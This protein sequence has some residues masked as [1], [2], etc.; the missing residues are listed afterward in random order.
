[1]FC[2]ATFHFKKKTQ[3]F[4]SG[5]FLTFFK[6]C[7]VIIRKNKLQQLFQAMCHFKFKDKDTFLLWNKTHVLGERCCLSFSFA[8]P[9]HKP[10]TL[11]YYS[12]SQQ[13][14]E[15][16]LGTSWV[17]TTPIICRQPVD[18]QGGKHEM[19]APYRY[20]CEE[21]HCGHIV[22]ESWKDGG[23]EAEDDDHRPHSSSG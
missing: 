20:G 2:P 16:N 19:V 6:K 13:Q 23:N 15:K 12:C 3:K 1:M 9:V 21:H 22:Q 7:V 10:T 5:T 18:T 8:F 17:T 4:T 11:R 14:R